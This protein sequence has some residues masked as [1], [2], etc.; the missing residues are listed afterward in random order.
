MSAQSI[1]PTAAILV[2]NDWLLIGISVRESVSLNAQHGPIDLLTQ[3]APVQYWC[4]F[5]LNMTQ[6]VC[7]NQ[8][9]VVIH[10]CLFV[11]SGEVRGADDKQCR[12]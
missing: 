1:R 8:V 3:S 2:G 7:P 12:E 6:Y 4:A 5:L 10:L 11:R 9:L